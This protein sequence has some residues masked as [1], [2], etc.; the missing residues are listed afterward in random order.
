MKSTCKFKARILLV[1]MFFFHIL[2]YSQ[3]HWEWAQG[4][5]G[6]LYE[7]KATSIAVDQSGNSY[8][9]GFITN[10]ASFGDTTFYLDPMVYCEPFLAKYSPEGLRLWVKNIRLSWPQ[11]KFASVRGSGMGI[12]LNSHNQICLTGYFTGRADFNNGMQLN[13]MDPGVQAGFI[14]VFDNSG[15]TL[16]ATQ[17]GQAFT[18]DL[19]NYCV[20]QS[21]TVDRENNCYVTGFFDGNLMIGN[22]SFASPVENIFVAKYDITGK[23][24]WA[25]AAGGSG[26]DEG[27]SISVDTLGHCFITGYI[28][29]PSAVFGPVAFGPDIFLN[30][31]GVSCMF[32]ASYDQGTGFLNW[33]KQTVQKFDFIHESPG[34]FGKGIVS[35]NNGGCFITGYFDGIVQFQGTTLA[36]GS[37]SGDDI[38]VARYNAKGNLMWIN[39]EGGG[40]D[41]EATCISYGNQRVYI[42]GYISGPTTFNNGLV[43]VINPPL[44]GY[45]QAF[46][47]SFDAAGEF[48]FATRTVGPAFDPV[49]YGIA[50]GP[51]LPP[52]NLGNRSVYVA[53]ETPVP[54][55]MIFFNALNGGTGGLKLS[56]TNIGLNAF[57]AAYTTSPWE[58]RTSNETYTKEFNSDPSMSFKVY[59]NPSNGLLLL[60]LNLSAN[61]PV[62]LE[63]SN[64]L[65]KQVYLECVEELAGESMLQI[66]AQDLPSGIYLLKVTA[67]D[68]CK[69]KLIEIE[70]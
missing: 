56:A 32:L 45:Y 34:S 67:K 59:P 51:E 8:V 65:G 60:Q 61:S 43:K 10:I 41:A 11:G 17:I 22:N 5:G 54:G 20:S 31:G 30:S 50:A 63:I 36:S 23:S 40:N 13:S 39:Q 21:I 58:F 53:G 44:F 62:K 4:F 26:F 14:A 15:K 33:A 19:M 49:I 18:G 48:D 1:S 66:K 35:D 6:H 24:I 12:V 42:G 27:S 55:D 9:T 16:W 28:S 2:T 52:I 29:S 3:S 46:I 57:A 64:M 69:Q 25:R 38:F 37:L 47:A 68:I 7:T 70:H